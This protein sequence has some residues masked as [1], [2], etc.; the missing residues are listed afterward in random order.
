[1]F[2]NREDNDDVDEVEERK[3]TDHVLENDNDHGDDGKM[4]VNPSRLR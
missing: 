3:K 4:R 1:M 2:F